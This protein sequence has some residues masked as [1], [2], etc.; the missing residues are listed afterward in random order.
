M[1]LSNRSP[2]GVEEDIVF[3]IRFALTEGFGA[4]FANSELAYRLCAFGE[5]YG[6]ESV[7]EI[8]EEAEDDLSPAI[9][10]EHS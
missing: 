1:A 3:K 10:D 9:E 4:D 7:L 6:L 8:L 5:R 2:E